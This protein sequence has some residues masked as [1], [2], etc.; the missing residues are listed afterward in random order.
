MPMATYTAVLHLPVIAH[1]DHQRIQIHDRIQ[2]IERP[3]LP[4]AHFLQHRIGDIGNECGTDID[5]IDLF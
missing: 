4:G 1:L 5:A 2:R 3:A